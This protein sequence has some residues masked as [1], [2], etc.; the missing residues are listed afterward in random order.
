MK[1]RLV[2]DNGDTNPALPKVLAESPRIR[3]TSAWR[4]MQDAMEDYLQGDLNDEHFIDLMVCY[5]DDEQLSADV[6]AME[7]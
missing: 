6:R 4:A 1:L 2:V 3:M 5:L 7:N